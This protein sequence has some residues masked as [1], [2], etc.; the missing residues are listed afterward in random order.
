MF[1]QNSNLAPYTK[2]HIKRKSRPGEPSTPTKP[3]NN[4]VPSESSDDLAKNKID[5]IEA[6]LSKS[7]THK[8]SVVES[9]ISILKKIITAADMY[10]MKNADDYTS[11]SS[12]NQ[13]QG[14]EESIYADH[15]DDNEQFN[16][17][18]SLS[19]QFSVNSVKWTIRVKA[20]KLVHELLKLIEQ[21]AQ[22]SNQSI[23]NIR[24]HLPDLIRISFVAATSPYDNLKLEGYGMFLYL[25]NKFAQ[26]EEEEADCPI[27][28][29]YRTQVMTA[30][31]PA[32]ESDA[33]PYITAI[34][35]QVI[36]AWICWSLDK[37][38]FDF[39]KSYS[40]ISASITKLETQSTNH[41]I[42]LFNES[43][44]EQERLA[45][46]GSW[47]EVY[48]NSHDELKTN[49]ITYAE[50]YKALIKTKVE[51]LIKY[52]W[53]ALKDYA[54][55][56]G[57]VTKTINNCHGN[58]DVYTRETALNL[59]KPVWHRVTLALCLWLSEESKGGLD[60]IHEG[61]DEKNVGSKHLLD[62]KSVKFLCGII[63][64]ELLKLY[65]SESKLNIETNGSIESV[66]S[67]LNQLFEDLKL[68]SILAEDTRIIYEFHCILSYAIRKTTLR[69]TPK[70]ND[71]LLKTSQNMIKSLIVSKE[72]L[73][74]E[75]LSMIAAAIIYSTNKSLASI[76]FEK[77]QEIQVTVDFKLFLLKLD[78]LVSMIVTHPSII[79]GKEDI[80]NCHLL[81]LKKCLEFVQNMFVCCETINRIAT[82][83]DL[84]N[85]YSIV[86]GDELFSSL[87]KFVSEMIEKIAKLGIEPAV[88]ENVIEV[89]GKYLDSIDRIIS[90]NDSDKKTD[91][92]ATL[93]DLL[94]KFKPKF[95]SDGELPEL[96]R[97]FIDLSIQHIKKINAEYP[98]NIRTILSP[99]M[100]QKLGDMIKL[101]KNHPTSVLTSVQ[102]KEPRKK[103]NT[104]KSSKVVLKMD[105]SNFYKGKEKQ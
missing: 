15:V 78:C 37:S 96:Q 101:L 80:S 76:K 105:F 23:K 49:A 52:W 73:T 100:R 30:V 28:G 51:T 42:K 2:V 72:N 92:L 16:T 47:A 79:M 1:R 4:V 43:E 20:F 44:L 87:I 36:S 6:I 86:H 65:A 70:L 41:N 84:P 61:E 103:D 66:L 26:V 17:T 25:V 99:E 57:P 71:L 68:N 67:S 31:K 22:N 91:L 11:L 29:Q 32:F 69:L 89:L 54:L 94:L 45:I 8:L 88:A 82:L 59:F 48:I 64:N 39:K 50:E 63:M 46:L 81:V 14:L 34:A 24:K 10:S 98:E 62:H 56:I 95:N 77:E 55:L 40:L 102:L 83:L 53:E 85:E 60:I 3:Q 58:Q 9:W 18:E 27:L 5:E 75:Q 33:P 21:Q 38:L 104:V 93:V 97:K 90:I 74:E 13:T 12:G 19:E 7:E 35:S